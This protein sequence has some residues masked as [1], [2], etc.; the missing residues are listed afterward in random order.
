MKR[1]V[2]SLL[3]V[4]CTAAAFAGNYT[5]NYPADTKI[6]HA[7]RAL[8][9]I[10]LNLD[11]FPEQTLDVNQGVGGLLH[12]DKES[13][14]FVGVAGREANIS[15]GWIGTWMNTYVYID[16]NRDSV[17]DEESELIAYSNLDGQN[18]A[19]ASTGNGNVLLPPTFC[20]PEGLSGDYCMRIKIDWNSKDPGGSTV[21]GNDIVSNGGVI[22]DAGLL[23]RDND[24]VIS[25]S[26][27]NGSV[28][29]VDGTPIDG[30]AVPTT[31]EL[32]LAVKAD[33]G[34]I[35]DALKVSA[36][37]SAMTDDRTL[38]NGDLFAINTLYT[39]AALKDGVISIP[40]ERLVLG[41]KIEAEF[42][43]SE[44]SS[45]E[46]YAPLYSG[47]KSA[48]DGFTMIRMSG[49]RR[50]INSTLRH[51][52][53][54]ADFMVNQL[55]NSEV[56]LVATFSGTA[57][58]FR[59][60]VDL[61]QD[62][63]FNDNADAM[64]CEIIASGTD[65]TT[66]TGALPE[67]MKTGVYRARLD[68]EGHSS[69]DF[70]LNVHNENATVRLQP[71]NALVL[72]SQNTAIP[73][74][75][76]TLSQLQLKSSAVL[77]G[78]E[79]S[80]VIVR[81]GQNLTGPQFI[82]GNPQWADYEGK[83]LSSGTIN[84]P[85]TVMNGD[86]EIYVMY[87]QG[88]ESEWIKV[89]GDEFCDGKLDKKRWKYQPRAGSTWNR[90]VAQNARQHVLV[91]TFENGYYNSHCIPT[92]DEFTDETQPMISGA[93]ISDG[94]FS[95]KYGRIEA[96]IK[97]TPHVGNFPAF[98]MMP[99]YSE[100]KDLGLNGWPKDG[101]IDIW[102]QIDADNRSHHTVHSGWTGWNKY[103]NWEA[104]KVQSPQS[105]SSSACDMNLW[106]TYAL[107]WDAEELRWYVDGVQVFSYK[108]QHYVEEGSDKYIEKV[109]WP[110]DKHFYIILNQSVGNGSWARPADETF[111]YLTLFD[112]VRVY[113]K[114]G[115]LDYES[116][117]EGNGD[118]ENFYVP[119]KDVDEESSIVNVEVSDLY[120]GEPEYYDL[121]GRRVSAPI[122]TPG[123]YIKKTGS[124]A[125]K[126]FVR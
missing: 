120:D 49:T 64:S 119:A 15:L 71:L 17:F 116:K 40:V 12:H 6:T 113:Q 102:E 80:Q 33:E 55:I 82:C 93:I 32:E 99:S 31:G 22:V 85:S 5:T 126:I 50:K 104:P 61:N 123:I 4:A 34:Y 111:N 112:Y 109:T 14:Y 81:H 41:A 35:F 8:H 117:I 45:D 28:T 100:L 106:H 24:G 125:V 42:L 38:V 58:N 101:E 79:P 25:L 73:N 59:F 122:A 19:G 56:T 2:L 86:V 43:P 92:P 88:A 110:F 121:N 115:E 48:T 108:N 114:K 107:E 96:R 36:G 98:W 39:A 23:V 10:T 83:I 68:A 95:V 3:A 30:I 69:V 62:G 84:I 37:I 54:S 105:S 87:T 47:E 29:L 27:N 18:S 46:P 44:Q 70:F 74:E 94:N 60:L 9:N 65:A 16:L 91:N 53:A 63:I 21:E 7:T 26:A 103:C 57:S 90:L 13:H 51:T 72:T 89:W 11:G 67:G 66:L 124:R 97:T 52:P 76:A 118:A 77:P 78:F 1:K 20:I 75:V